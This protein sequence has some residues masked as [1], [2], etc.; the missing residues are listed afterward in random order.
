MEDGPGERTSALNPGGDQNPCSSVLLPIWNHEA[1]KGKENKRERWEVAG[2]WRFLFK[3]LRN[4][5]NVKL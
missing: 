4:A 3:M 2:I 5:E 1:E